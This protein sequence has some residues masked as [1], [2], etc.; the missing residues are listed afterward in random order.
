MKKLKKLLESLIREII[1]QMILDG[2]IKIIV[3]N[4]SISDDWYEVNGKKALLSVYGK[5][6]SKD[7]GMFLRDMQMPSRPPYM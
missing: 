7:K 5:T 4:D 3:A 2:D 6:Q 1:T